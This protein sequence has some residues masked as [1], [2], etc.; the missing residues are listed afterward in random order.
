[1]YTKRQKQIIA[2][3]V[4]AKD[5]EPSIQELRIILDKAQRQ[6]DELVI[7]RIYSL[8]E[9]KFEGEKDKPKEIDR[10]EF[11]RLMKELSD[12]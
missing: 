1:M 6:E 2:G 7:A 3:K 9:D 12:L 10:E 5:H 11:L 4:P 8:Y